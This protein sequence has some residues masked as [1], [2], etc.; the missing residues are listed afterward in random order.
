[1]FTS[2][3]YYIIVN[4]Q[5]IAWGCCWYSLWH[6]AKLTA[7]LSHCPHACTPLNTTL[8]CT[9][10]TYSVHKKADSFRSRFRW[11]LTLGST[12]KVLSIWV[13]FWGARFGEC[14]H[15]REGM[16]GNV[17]VSTLSEMWCDMPPLPQPHSYNP[18]PPLKTATHASAPVLVLNF[19]L[20]LPHTFHSKDVP[21]F[22]PALKFS[23]NTCQC[24]WD[25][26]VGSWQQHEADK[27]RRGKKASLGHHTLLRWICAQNF[28]RLAIFIALWQ[29]KMVQGAS[30]RVLDLMIVIQ[31]EQT[32]SWWKKARVQGCYTLL[33]QRF[34]DFVIFTS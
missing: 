3:T 13:L 15:Q 28:K 26:N 34:S 6:L 4:I 19:K 14:I 32:K 29:Y 11:K 17:R 18:V 7:T 10:G 33:Y 22:A 16:W 31:H 1:M 30:S 20:F 5:Y 12:R 23:D 21:Q 24:N 27:K 2:I 8:V 25:A 9:S